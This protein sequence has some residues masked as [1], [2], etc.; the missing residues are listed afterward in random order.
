MECREEGVG[1]RLW[2]REEGVGGRLERSLG[3]GETEER[4]KR[5]TL[6]G[7]VKFPLR[8][9]LGE[10]ERPVGGGLGDVDRGGLGDVDC[11]DRFAS[12]SEK[13]EESRLN[14]KFVVLKFED[15]QIEAVRT[16]VVVLFCGTGRRP[17]HIDFL[18][19]L[20]KYSMM[21]RE[22]EVRWY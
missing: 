21:E 19:R 3:V 16:S 15:A 13:E 2:F 7:E 5:L 4:P 17:S 9:G 22:K 1:G 6:G 8:V 18:M 10:R 11:F 12:I 14:W 20:D